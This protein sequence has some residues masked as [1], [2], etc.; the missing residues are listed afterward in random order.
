MRDL[1]QSFFIS[2][3]SFFPFKFQLDFNILN[4][5]RNRFNSQ[6]RGEKGMNE[7]LKMCGIS[8]SFPGVRALSNVSLTLY[9]G[10]VHALCGENGAGKSTLMKIL[11]GVYQANEGKYSLMAKKRILKTQKKHSSLGSA[12]FFK[13]STCSRI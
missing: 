7:L 1:I 10:E 6:A 13:S 8:K 4:S 2:L 3:Q 9:A 5:A 11:S 12:L